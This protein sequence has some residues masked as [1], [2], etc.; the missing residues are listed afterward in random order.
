MTYYVSGGTLNSLAYSL[1][2]ITG[3]NGRWCSCQQ[4]LRFLSIYLCL[5]T[6]LFR[7]KQHRENEY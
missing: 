4:I 2:L 7:Q 5:W 1:V 3:R 6:A